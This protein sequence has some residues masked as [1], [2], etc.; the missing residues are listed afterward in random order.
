MVFFSRNFIPV[1]AKICSMII[2]LQLEFCTICRCTI[3]ST[4]LTSVVPS[5]KKKENWVTQSICNFGFFILPKFRS[6]D[7]V[8]RLLGVKAVFS[9]RMLRMKHFFI[10]A[11]G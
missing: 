1:H 8:L 3:L 7:V 9:P 5:Q 10:E 6:V 2:F 11:L 4:N